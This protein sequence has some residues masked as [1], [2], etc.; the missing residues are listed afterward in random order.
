MGTAGRG[1]SYP[2]PWGRHGPWPWYRRAVQFIRRLFRPAAWL[3][4]V[5]MLARARAD[6]VACAGGLRPRQPLGGAL[7]AGG[8]VHGR[9]RCRRRLGR[10]WRAPGQWTAVRPGRQRQPTRIDPNL[11]PGKS[12][13]NGLTAERVLGEGLFRRTLLCEY[14]AAERWPGPEGAGAQ[15]QPDLR[16][17][18]HRGQRRQ[19]G[20]RYIVTD[21][22]AAPRRPELAPQPGRRQSG[23]PRVLGLPSVP[24]AHRPCGSALGSLSRCLP[25]SRHEP[26]EFRP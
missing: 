4:L 15:R 6:V 5:A 7:L 22:R 9:A 11:R 16:E 13:T 1:C 3:A 2:R 8:R 25:S 12:H 17:L 14:S 20:E 26:Q 19:P 18:A 10:C 23:Q 21:A 24:E